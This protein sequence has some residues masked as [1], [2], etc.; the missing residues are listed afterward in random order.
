MIEQRRNKSVMF[1]TQMVD[2][3]RPRHIRVVSYIYIYATNTYGITTVEEPGVVLYHPGV[4][5]LP[6]KL[7]CDVSPGV[8]WLVNGISYLLNQL[9]NGNLP[10]HNV[11]GSNVLITNIPMNNS[12][13]VCSD[14]ITNEGVYRIL[15]AGEYA[16]MFVMYTYELYT[17]N[18]VIYE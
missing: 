9:Q 6:I 15:V 5:V 18:S 17:H 14:G 16:N 13:Y 8:G 11:N 3:R 2:F 10:G 4:T 12:Q 7:T 1:C